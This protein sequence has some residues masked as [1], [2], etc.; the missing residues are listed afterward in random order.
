MEGVVVV[1][2][3]QPG[4][5]IGTIIIINIIQMANQQSAHPAVVVDLVI[6]ILVMQRSL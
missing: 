3:I 6:K 1:R 5:L 2:I 4:I